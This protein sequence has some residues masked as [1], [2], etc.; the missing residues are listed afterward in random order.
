MGTG[1][2]MTEAEESQEQEKPQDG[3]EIQLNLEETVAKLQKEL[4]EKV[5]L[6][7]D[8]LNQLKYLQ[9]D[10]DNYR[11]KFD[12]EKEV[13]ISL[14]E[15]RLVTELLN[16]VDDFDRILQ[17]TDV[18]PAKEGLILLYKNLVKI[19]EGHG[20]KRIETVGKKF[21]PQYHEAFCVEVCDCEEGTIIEEFQP[22]YKLKFKVIRPAK[23]KIAEN[24]IKE[25]GENHGKGENY[26]N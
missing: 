6:A 1:G 4:E 10:F 15:E 11:K 21:N 24:R 3:K 26:R 8:R 13:I 5:K 19:L 12:K 18:L 9:A 7:D 22:G 16:I 25:E 2:S 20:L 14:A 17:S 23:V